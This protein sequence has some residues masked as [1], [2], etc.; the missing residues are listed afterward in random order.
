LAVN[1]SPE[2]IGPVPSNAIIDCQIV[3]ANSTILGLLPIFEQEQRRDV[4]RSTSASLST[5][6]FSMDDILNKSTVL[7][8]NPHWQAIHV[9]R[10]QRLS[11]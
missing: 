9:K 3:K 1:R 10:L 7:V 8:L 6:T 11:A 2:Q 5:L 4:N